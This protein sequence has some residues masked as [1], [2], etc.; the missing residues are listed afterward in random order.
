MKSVYSERG[1]FWDLNQPHANNRKWGTP[2][3][4]N[5]RIPK[6]ISSILSDKENFAELT[7]KVFVKS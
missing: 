7:V 3:P 2:N 1:A 4:Q 5:F 6:F